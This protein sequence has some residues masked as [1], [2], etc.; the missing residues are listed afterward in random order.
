MDYNASK[1][2]IVCQY[3]NSEFDPKEF[4]KEAKAAKETKSIETYEGKSYTCSQ[5]GATLL[6][7]DETAITFCSY[8][9][10]Q[11]M[12][13]S[14][15]I[16]QN[17]PDFIIPFEVDKDTCIN[18][19]KKLVSKALFA[20]DYMKANQTVEKFRGIYMPYCIYKLEYN[21]VAKNNGSKYA[22]RRGDYEIYN[23]YLITADV[24][25][26]Y[27]GISFDLLSKFYDNYSTAIPYNTQEKKEFNLNYMLGYY[28]DVLDVNKDVYDAA[29]RKIAVDD[30]TKQLLKHHEYAKYGCKKPT[31]EVSVTERK[32]GMFPVYFL[33]IRNKDN[34]TVNYAVVNGQTGKVVADLPI[35]F[36]K[37]IF[38]SLLISVIIFLLIDNL[39]VLTP[40]NI[41]VFSIVAGLI[42]LIISAN[43]LTKIKNRETHMDD[44]GYLSKIDRKVKEPKQKKFRYLYKELI[45][46]LIP[47]LALAFNFVNDMYYYG[48]AAI[49]LIL[50]V[51]SFYDLVKEHNILV[52]N[53]LPQLEKRGGDESE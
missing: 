4:K 11:A 51:L 2:K 52:S 39:V 28:A 3:C 17:N 29:A 9:G 35:A 13:E 25:A 30:T 33:A 21:G 45:A 24:D 23:D 31:A 53:K 26:S 6:T 32:I 16:K 44:Q 5:C 1:K 14:K 47:I 7:F 43:Q 22:K 37:Y 18:N 50:V 15:M 40:K 49:A 46:V 42:S 12:V 48:A 38:A 8:C 36:T 27:D 19:Y 41:A 34:K 20:P 10:S